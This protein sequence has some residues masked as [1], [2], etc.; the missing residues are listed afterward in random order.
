MILDL[1][2]IEAALVRLAGVA[3]PAPVRPAGAATPRLLTVLG[4][5]DAGGLVTV[6]ELALR[7]SLHPS[8]ASRLVQKALRGGLLSRHAAQGDGRRVELRLT[9]RGRTLSRS[10]AALQ[11]RAL[12]QALRGFPPP[13]RRQLASLLTRLVIA[14]EAWHGAHRSSPAAALPSRGRP[15]S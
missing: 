1:Q 11:Q 10:A 8:R 6:G 9:L 2:Q 12:V 13:E 5:V 15:R 3:R 7:L 4:A 14:L